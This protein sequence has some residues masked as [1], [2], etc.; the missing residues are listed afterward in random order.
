[1]LGMFLNSSTAL[2]VASGSGDGRGV[3]RRA[4]AA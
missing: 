3:P 1:M 2:E 4:K